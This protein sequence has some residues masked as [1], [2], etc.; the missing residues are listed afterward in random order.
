MDKKARQCRIAGDIA[1]QV[2]GKVLFEVVIDTRGIAVLVGRGVDVSERFED[3]RGAL[4]LRFPYSGQHAVQQTNSFF[5]STRSAGQDSGQ[6]ITFRAGRHR[7]Q[8]RLER[9][10]PKGSDFCV[11]AIRGRPDV[12]GPYRSAGG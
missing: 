10:Q 3:D 7:L 5:K 8:P 2:T 11:R 1:M 9:M 6:V 4:G 12:V